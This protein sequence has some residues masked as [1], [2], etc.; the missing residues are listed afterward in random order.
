MENW[1][2]ILTFSLDYVIHLYLS[3]TEIYAARVS[4]FFWCT[5]FHSPCQYTQGKGRSTRTGGEGA[6]RGLCRRL[7]GSWPLIDTQVIGLRWLLE[8]SKTTMGKN[9]DPGK[10]YPKLCVGIVYRFSEATSHH[11][12][13]ISKSLASQVFLTAFQ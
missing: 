5:F 8:T 11:M 3:P 9:L 13:P 4:A 10:T 6:Y 7:D 2:R 1:N 12:A